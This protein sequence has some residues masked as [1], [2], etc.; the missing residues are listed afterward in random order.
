MNNRKEI[1]LTLSLDEANL[2]L[3]ALG[4]QPFAKVF[5]LIEK[6]QQQASQQLNKME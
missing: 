5:G 1:K 6:I 2:I 4:E 3:D